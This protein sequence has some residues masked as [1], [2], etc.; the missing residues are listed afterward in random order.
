VTSTTVTGLTNGTAYT[1]RV[2][3][4]NGL[5]TGAYSTVS[6]AVTPSVPA[7]IAGLQLWLDASDSATLFDATTGGSLVAA[8][9][10]VAR[11]Q[12][13]SGNGRH[14]TQST[15]GSRPLRK[16]AIQGGKDVLRFDGTDDVI[17]LES[18]LALNAAQSL[19]VVFKP[20]STIT[21][22]SYGQLLSGG[23]F[24]GAGTGTSQF[25]LSLGSTSGSI[26][27][28]RL[29]LFVVAEDGNGNAQVYGH[30]QTSADVSGCTLV[31][32]S[33][34]S[35]GNTFAGRVNGSASFATAAD[36][37]GFSSIQSRRPTVF[38]RVGSAPSSSFCAADVCEIIIYNSALSDADRSAIESYLMTKWGI[39]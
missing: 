12:D 26:Q 10:G 16:T 17:A 1:F 11:W 23:T 4:V 30:G 2:A 35:T 39:A 38:R 29:L 24:S 14:A 32:Y 6:A 33:F 25:G 9:G 28:E 22:S 20:T 3:A 31:Y 13:K 37:G 5:G 7:S 15:S 18:D 19:F 8:D 21:T 27:N 36:P 34:A